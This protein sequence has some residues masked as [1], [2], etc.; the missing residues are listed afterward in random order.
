MRDL[1]E[2]TNRR[3]PRHPKSRTRLNLKEGGSAVIASPAK[4]RTHVASLLS[5]S[6][7]TRLFATDDPVELRHLIRGLMLTLSSTLVL[8]AV[9]WMAWG[10][11][12][13]A[14]PYFQQPLRDIR[15]HGLNRLTPQELLRGVGLKPGELLLD[16]DPYQL[17]TRLRA[18]PLV[19]EVDLRRQFPRRLHLNVREHQPVARLRVANQVF[20]VDAEQRVLQRI[21]AERSS[22]EDARL[23]LVTGLRTQA[24]Q[25]GMQLQSSVLAQGLE[26]LQALDVMP[27]EA[28]TALRVDLSEPQNLKLVVLVDGSRKPLEVQLGGIGSANRVEQ[29]RKLYPSL[30]GT[31]KKPQMVDLRHPDR[32]SMLQ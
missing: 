30:L 9:G 29:F 20:L 19:R 17:A 8:G 22:A 25:P 15:I 4:R 24:L 28:R 1:K 27:E 21:A 31:L 11:A 7:W 13:V 6:F 16:I 2:H 12:T 5:K 26:I 3:T 32:V 14:I 18:H 10:T 23:L